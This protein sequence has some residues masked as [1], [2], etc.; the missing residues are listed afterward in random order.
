MGHLLVLA[1]KK[2]I[3]SQDEILTTSASFHVRDAVDVTFKVDFPLGV[4][5]I[6]KLSVGIQ[7][8]AD[9]GE[10]GTAAALA[11]E[12]LNV[13]VDLVAALAEEL[14][15]L[16]L[17]QEA[18]IKVKELETHLDNDV[19]HS[20]IRGDEFHVFYFSHEFIIFRFFLFYNDF[21]FRFFCVF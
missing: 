19:L 17:G 4:F 1:L 2:I 18:A 7:I 5:E 15:A 12:A 6:G 14:E 16:Y 9:L 21:G 3:L 8:H 11:E 13:H 20:V 10:M